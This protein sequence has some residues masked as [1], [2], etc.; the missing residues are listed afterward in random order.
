MI[1]SAAMLKRLILNLMLLSLF[2]VTQI[3]IVTHE[4][5]HFSDYQKQ[6]HSEKNVAADQCGQCIA[7]EQAANGAASTALP[8]I[9]TAEGVFH[10]ATATVARLASRLTPSY[11]ARAP[12]VFSIS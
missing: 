1:Q 6:S 11:S 8:S 4:I 7:Y 10:F 5:S 12:P 2:A 9:P 3:G